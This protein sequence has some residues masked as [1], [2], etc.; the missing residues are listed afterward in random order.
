MREFYQVVGK[1]QPSDMVILVGEVFSGCAFSGSLPYFLRSVWHSEPW[2]QIL[3]NATLD[4]VA[5]L[6]MRK[7][8]L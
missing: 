3:L 1:Q 4:L 2:K 7:K 5:L 8:Q 6:L